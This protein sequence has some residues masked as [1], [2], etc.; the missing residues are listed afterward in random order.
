MLISIAALSRKRKMRKI[1]FVVALLITSVW[2]NVL[3]AEERF[4]AHHPFLYVSVPLAAASKPNQPL[5]ELGFAI[6]Q[7][8]GLTSAYSDASRQLPL[9]N[10]TFTSQGLRNWSAFGIDVTKLRANGDSASDAEDAVHVNPLFVMLGTM[11]VGGLV[12][13]AIA[14]SAAES[15]A[16]AAPDFTPRTNVSVSLPPL[17]PPSPPP[18]GLATWR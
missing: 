6:R 14:N 8:Y 13:L 18:P 3:L 16:G 15:A 11:L 9:V 12:A 2:S 4:D 17:P 7:S 10:L 1:L 5:A